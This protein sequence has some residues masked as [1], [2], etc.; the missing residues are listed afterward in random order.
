MEKSVVVKMMF[1]IGLLA[2]IVMLL[3]MLV[4][5]TSLG[6]YRV[7]QPLPPQNEI[8]DQWREIPRRFPETISNAE[9]LYFIT[10]ELRGIRLQLDR[11]NHNLEKLIEKQDER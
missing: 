1:G 10:C 4:P 3:M 2:F 6:Q 7:P 5:V 11:L 9:G 8:V